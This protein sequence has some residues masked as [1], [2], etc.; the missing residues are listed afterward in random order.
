MPQSGDSLSLSSIVSITRANTSPRLLTTA[1]IVLFSYIYMRA[2]EEEAE[3]NLQ[4]GEIIV[5]SI[6]TLTSLSGVLVI[7]IITFAPV[8]GMRSL[9]I[10]NVKVKIRGCMV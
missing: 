6:E 5:S 8:K 7:S 3:Q 4:L 1:A 2:R 10:T 9:L